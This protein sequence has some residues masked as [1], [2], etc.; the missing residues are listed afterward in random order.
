MDAN[1]QQK[2]QNFFFFEMCKMTMNQ[3]F[4]QALKWPSDAK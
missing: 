4:L 2:T 3:D 1:E